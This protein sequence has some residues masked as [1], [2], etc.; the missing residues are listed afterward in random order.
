MKVFARGAPSSLY[1]RAYF[2]DILGFGLGEGLD[3]VNEPKP[4]PVFFAMLVNEHS[5]EDGMGSGELDDLFLA[6]SEHD[7]P[8]AGCGG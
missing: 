3:L 6:L 7:F 2:D 5:D 1:S 8:E 4:T